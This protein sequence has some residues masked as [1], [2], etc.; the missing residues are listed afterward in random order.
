MHKPLA[1]SFAA[2]LL[3]AAVACGNSVD[4]P[5]DCGVAPTDVSCTDPCGIPGTLVCQQ[6]RWV[7]PVADDACEIYDCSE[8]EHDFGDCYDDCGERYDPFCGPTGYECA[9]REPRCDRLTTP[10]YPALWSDGF[11]GPGES[12]PVAVQTDAAGNVYVMSRVGKYSLWS[13]Q[14]L[15]EEAN[16]PLAVAKYDVF[17]NRQWI[18][19]IDMAGLDGGMV[20]HPDGSLYLL[21]MTPPHTYDSQ[22]VALQ[23]VSML[24]GS[25]G[26]QIPMGI[27]V[28]HGTFLRMAVDDVTGDF[29]FAGISTSDVSLGTGSMLP[30][31]DGEVFVARFD[32][33]M[34]Q[35][36]GR[37]L[38][39]SHAPH[40]A[41]SPAGRVF[42]VGQYVDDVTVDGTA[43]PSPGPDGKN[44]YIASFDPSL[45]QLE[46]VRA[47]ES[48][49][50]YLG[51]VEPTDD[52]GAVFSGRFVEQAQLDD[53]SLTAES[54]RLQ[55]I[56][57][58]V[59][60]TG[61]AV[62]V[63]SL[64]AQG[65]S[66]WPPMQVALLS[67]GEIFAAGSTIGESPKVAGEYRDHDILTAR[68][69]A[70]NGNLLWFDS[71]GDGDANDLWYLHTNGHLVAMA[72]TFA[73]ELDLGQGLLPYFGIDGPSG[74]VGT[75]DP[76]P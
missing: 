47:L 55:P 61:E 71:F 60:G 7:C 68:L 20:I 3:G 58:R 43:W 18:R 76:A 42:L 12:N 41:L 1:C 56:V 19:Q 2:L 51:D 34:N 74:F 67:S 35:I 46:W 72:G 13:D 73:S 44:G 26:T 8:Y 40:L 69:D 10:S 21:G 45:G 15:L 17:G 33:G 49:S 75:F 50:A 53:V 48:R 24:D 66:D 6:G 28:T 54:G 64:G 14:T 25:L 65:R 31:S 22:P 62:F 59:D 52:G 70:T 37:R 36:W 5:W 57:G 63:V 27:E 38:S 4:P 32:A 11:G 23:A 29:A 39:G 30:V 9:A 16:G